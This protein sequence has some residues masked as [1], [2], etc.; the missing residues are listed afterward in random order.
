MKEVP[1]EKI[2]NFNDSQSRQLRAKTGI[3]ISPPKYGFSFVDNQL[4]SSTRGVTQLLK[5]KHYGTEVDKSYTDS[6]G[7]KI[8][9]HFKKKIENVRTAS[10]GA[11]SKKRNVGIA[12]IVGGAG[13]RAY[14]EFTA[15]SGE[16]KY[17][18]RLDSVADEDRF[19]K[20]RTVMGHTSKHDAENKLLEKIARE[21]GGVK[22]QVFPD[23]T[24]TVYL[25]SEIA[26]CASCR[27]LIPQ[28]KK[29]FPN[30]KMIFVNDTRN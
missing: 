16:K 18:G 13:N 19:F 26:Y 9:D 3:G 5:L 12:G 7:L 11:N 28:F 22:G 21:L 25:A 2:T 10:M 27:E 30:S 15:I 8:F 6:G 23:V 20:H 14:K 29:M 24:E 4:S 17:A 1:F